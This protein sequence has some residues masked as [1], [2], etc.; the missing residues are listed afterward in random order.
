MKNICPFYFPS[1]LYFRKCPCI[2]QTRSLF[3]L[4]R[5]DLVVM[6]VRHLVVGQGRSS[7]VIDLKAR[8]K[9]EAQEELLEEVS[10][11]VTPHQ[12]RPGTVQLEGEGSCDRK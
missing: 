11:W 7:L 10:F 2:L 4:Q 9:H 6:N 1:T 5:C 8:V 3:Y 12:P